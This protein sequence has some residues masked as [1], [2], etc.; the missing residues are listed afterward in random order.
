MPHIDF[1]TVEDT[2]SLERLCG[3]A[4]LKRAEFYMKRHGMSERDACRAAIAW[5]KNMKRQR[6][7]RY[8]HGTGA[9]DHVREDHRHVH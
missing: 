3:R 2:N 7:M 9:Y 8:S 6:R 4:A 5:W 1:D